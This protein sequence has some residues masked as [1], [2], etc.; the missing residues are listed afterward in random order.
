MAPVTCTH[1]R[2]GWGKLC[3]KGPAPSS[4]C[5]GTEREGVRRGTAGDPALCVGTGSSFPAL[6]SDTRLTRFRLSASFGGASRNKLL[7]A[8]S[9]GRCMWSRVTERP[10]HVPGNGAQHLGQQRHLEEGSPP[11]PRPHKGSPEVFPTSVVPGA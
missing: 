6:T 8:F 2:G 10:C 5:L 7:Q 11:Q 4:C 9:S 1:G 3:H